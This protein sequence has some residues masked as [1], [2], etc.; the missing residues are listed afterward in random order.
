MKQTVKNFLCALLVICIVLTSSVMAFAA[1]TG[2][3]NSD[4][5]VNSTDALGILKYTVGATPSKFDKSVADV[6]A[7]GKINSTDALAVLRIAVGIGNS[8]ELSKDEI[9]KLYNNGLAKVSEQLTCN[10]TISTD[11][12]GTVNKFLMNGEKNPM[13]ESLLENTLNSDY[14]DEK[15]RFFNG[16]TTDGQKA[17]DIL[18]SINLTAN[19][20]KSAKAVKQGNGYKL[21]IV[22]VEETVTLD[23]L[24]PD[25]IDF[26]YCEVTYPGTNITAIIDNEGRIERVD[27]VSD[28]HMKASGHINDSSVYIDVLIAEEST[29]TFSY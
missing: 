29:Y 27:Y 23:E 15:Y 22:L 17:K 25:M 7:D 21:N 13:F 19:R 24:L 20:V 11:I 28:G 26:D 10:L 18:A 12:S 14:E 9:V 2:D 1:V 8:T 5:K 4:G 3:I 16:K 6:N